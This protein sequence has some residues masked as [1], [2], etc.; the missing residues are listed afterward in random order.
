MADDP[1]TP[2]SYA[3]PAWLVIVPSIV[4]V[5][6]QLPV[7]TNAIK[8]AANDFNVPWVLPW[9]ALVLTAGCGIATLA[10]GAV[11]FYRRAIGRGARWALWFRA[12]M[13]WN[14]A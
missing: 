3:G 2:D 6:T 1:N 9:V 12:R 5:A 14:R 11:W 7:V 8:T 10:G 13:P 4:S